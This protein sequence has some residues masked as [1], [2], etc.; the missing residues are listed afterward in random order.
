MKNKSG[1]GLN[2]KI[3]VL[4]KDF[5]TAIDRYRE[6]CILRNSQELADI[7]ILGNTKD[8]VPLRPNHKT[9]LFILCCNADDKSRLQGIN[10]LLDR[11]KQNGSSSFTSVVIT[12]GS[13]KDDDFK[14]A[15]VIFPVQKDQNF[16]YNVVRLLQ[17]LVEI[18]IKEGIG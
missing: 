3:I 2:I 11:S 6:E 15:N 1:N 12:C 9:D 18:S 13:A 14:E 10:D 17:I 5:Q 4:G 16:E 7:I 8:K